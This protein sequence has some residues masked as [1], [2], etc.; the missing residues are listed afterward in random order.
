VVVATKVNPFISPLTR[1]G[2]LKQAA[3][4]LES[5]Q[6]PCVDILYLHAPDHNTPIEETLEAVQQLYTGG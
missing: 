4:C 1:E 6:T 2:V 3:T 5:L